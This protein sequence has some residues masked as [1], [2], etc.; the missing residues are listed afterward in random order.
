MAIDVNGS[1][2]RPRSLRC[3]SEL[4]EPSRARLTAPWRFNATRRARSAT[5]SSYGSQ[6]PLFVSGGRRKK[7]TMATP[8]AN[9]SGAQR[10]HPLVDSATTGASG[11][12]PSSSSSSVDTTRANAGTGAAS[13]LATAGEAAASPFGASSD[14]LSFV[15]AAAAVSSTTPGAGASVFFSTSPISLSGGAESFLS[16]SGMVFLAARE[17]ISA[18]GRI[19]A[20]LTLNAPRL[21]TC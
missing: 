9:V 20:D 18:G 21:A 4:S 17:R 14:A 8:A 1:C 13:T 10:R 7:K 19:G 16:S 5:L 11:S 15:A 6:R 3:G 2:G 12:S